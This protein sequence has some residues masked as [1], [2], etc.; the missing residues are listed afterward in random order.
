MFYRMT[1]TVMAVITVTAEAHIPIAHWQRTVVAT[2]MGE[3]VEIQSPASAALART[4]LSNGEV[5]VL[6]NVGNDLVANLATDLWQSSEFMRQVN[7]Y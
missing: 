4:L 5:V 3:E 6:R 1:S 2:V 7:T